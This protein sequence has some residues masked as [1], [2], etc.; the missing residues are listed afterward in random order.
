MLTTL[1]WFCNW[2]N[3]IIYIK[4]FVKEKVRGW[5]ADVIQLAKIACSQPHAAYSAFNKG[6]GSC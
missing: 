2:I 6:W 4:Q 1:P 3:L 5:S